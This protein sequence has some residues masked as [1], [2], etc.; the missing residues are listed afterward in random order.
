MFERCHNP[1]EV[2]Y[3]YLERGF[4]VQLT[5]GKVSILTS[6]RLGA[7]VLPPRLGA[8]VKEMLADEWIVPVITYQR[9]RRDWIVLVGPNRGG[10]LKPPALSSL[11]QQ[12]IRILDQSA[13][14][15][16]PMTDTQIGW[17]WVA[18]PLNASA[19]PPRNLV[20]MAARRALDGS[21]P[22]SLQRC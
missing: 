9:E 2:A 22:T 18:P 16:L 19:V 1:N 21:V 13:R 14:V 7:V 11:A 15:W 20:L 17:F 10:A 6:D 5:F 4:P 12:G 3:V 8:A